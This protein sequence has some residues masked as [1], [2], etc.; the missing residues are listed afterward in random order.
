MQRA[1]DWENVIF[2]GLCCQGD[3][4]R[5]RSRVPKATPY[6]ACGEDTGVG[7]GNPFPSSKPSPGAPESRATPRFGAPLCPVATGPPCGATFAEGLTGREGAAGR[8]RQVKAETLKS[9]VA[10]APALRDGRRSDRQVMGSGRGREGGWSTLAEWEVP[11]PGAGDGMNW[12]LS[13]FQP[14]PVPVP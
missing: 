12:A 5:S 6:V 1:I 10:A 4:D 3:L 11:L 14:Q 13:P 2:T 8:T 7:C 9:L